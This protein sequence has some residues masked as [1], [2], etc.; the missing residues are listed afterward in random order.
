MDAKKQ[1]LGTW[2]LIAIEAQT[3]EGE[4]I[5]PFGD[6]PTG[7][8]MYDPNNLMSVVLMRAERK[9]FESNDPFNATAEEITGA[10]HGLEAYCGSYQINEDD[11]SIT[12]YVQ[13][14]RFPNWEKSEQIRFYNF[15]NNS[16]TLTTAPIMLKDT[17]WTVKLVWEKAIN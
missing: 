10:F 15:N 1:L 14:S 13:A 5:Y 9:K 2:Q 11:K 17:Q 16:L 6:S 7:L 3:S 4:K 8:L 12:H